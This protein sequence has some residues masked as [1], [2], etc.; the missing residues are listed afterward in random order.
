MKEASMR[1]LVF[2]FALLFLPVFV[3]C[4]GGESG[5]LVSV[6]QDPATIP[7]PVEELEFVVGLG[8]GSGGYVRDP[9]AG[10]IRMAG[11]DLRNDSYR[12]LLHDGGAG[13]DPSQIIVAVI[14]RK[15]GTAIGFGG[16]DDPIAFVPDKVIE[17]DVIL[18]A[19]SEGVEFFFTETGCLAYRTVRIAAFDD[20]DCDG[21]RADTD[22]DDH[23]PS[24]SHDHVEVCMN[25]VDDDC[26]DATPDD[27]TGECSHETD[28]EVL[29]GPAPCGFWKC[30]GGE[31][32]VLC[33]G[34]VD[35]DLDG[36]GVETVA[37]ACA[38]GDCDDGTD[39]ITNHNAR[40]CYSEDP[41]TEGIGVCI[42]GS[43][44]CAEGVWAGVCSG[45]VTPGGEA[46]NGL[47]DDCNGMADDGL[48]RFQCG[49]GACAT[50]V[51]SCEPGGVLGMC[52]PLAS[53]AV[54]DSTCDGTDDGCDG[55]IDEDCDSCVHVSANGSDASALLDGNVTPFR[56]IQTAIDWVV[57]D[58]TRPRNICVAPSASCALATTGIFSGAV[59]MADGVHVYGGYEYTTFGRC[60]GFNTVIQTGTG[61]GVRFPSGV[62]NPTVLDGFKI[63]RAATS[64]TAGVTVDGSTGAIISNVRITNAPVAAQSRGVHVKS[65]G[66]ALIFRS[67]IDGGGGS[68]V[69]IGVHAQGARV[70]LRENCAVLDAFGTCISY[71]GSAT[72]GV[73]S[74]IIGTTATGVGQAY[75]VF[76]EDSPGSVIEQSA[77]CDA[78]ADTGAAVRIKGNAEGTIIRASSINGWGGFVHSHGVWMED[79]GGAAPWIVDNH[80]IASTGDG[81]TTAVDA[82][83]AAGDCHPVIDA[84]F[85]ISGGGEGSAASTTGVHC[86][87]TAA[88]SSRCQVIGN[89]I[90]GATFGFPPVATGVRCEG[91]SCLRIENNYID[92][93]GGVEVYGIYMVGAGA[94]V[95]DNDIFGG[96]GDFSATGVYAENAWTR[97]ENNRISAGG[98][99]NFTDGTTYIGVRAVHDGSSPPGA[100]FGELNFNSNDV[101][102]LG[103]PVGCSSAGLIIDGNGQFGVYR[104]NIFRGGDC[105]MNVVVG[106]T[107]PN[108]D[109]RIFSH[110]DLDPYSSP[111]ALYY[112]DDTTQSLT[113]IAEVN[114]LTDM[115]VW[116][117]ISADAQYMDF[118]FDLHI[119]ATSPCAGMGFWDGAPLVDMDGHERDATPEIGADEL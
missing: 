74:G 11:R 119:Q 94:M 29:Y 6:T 59:T 30:N 37:G 52:T 34:C 109:P 48:P 67:A 81:A 9:A 100:S 51:P 97:F 69:S 25:G 114:G 87:P 39:L 4:G 47:D 102:A 44:F 56:N 83:R 60:G 88:A 31:C 24:R 5:I 32:E 98:L 43:E 19:A 23:D 95:A 42:S 108:A 45:D 63:D 77:A 91:G 64:S 106:E 15:S 20:L 90:Q 118:P 68:T 66:H 40:P 115:D 28:C 17:R 99:C 65:G 107:N 78:N 55:A 21:E 8:D 111:S 82:V 75:G 96:C 61:E 71:C 49:I 54:V 101:D 57:A 58:A 33:E 12:L 41:V 26:D 116:N 1:A 103:D 36:Y 72:S 3:A 84:N 92:G 7:D 18:A 46:C 50:S 79:C 104:N 93:H 110:N 86:L 2:R 105:S 22:C 10:V 89:A 27:C 117:N 80:Q 16:W 13:P 53:P 70:T 62:I 14:G 38:G 35:L 76:L 73:P 85:L 113:S 112:D